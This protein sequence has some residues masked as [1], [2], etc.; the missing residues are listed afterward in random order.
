MIY[1]PLGGGSSAITINTSVITGGTQG[2]VLFIGA[3]GVLQQDNANFFWDDTNNRLGIGTAAPTHLLEVKG[4][5]TTAFKVW[6]GTSGAAFSVNTTGTRVGIGVAS[7]GGALDVGGDRII[8]FV[9]GSGNI[10][11]VSTLSNGTGTMI[12][13]TNNG[14]FGGDVAGGRLNVLGQANSAL[15]PFAVQQGSGTA[16]TKLASFRD[17]SGTETLG[18]TAAGG[19]TVN[20]AAGGNYRFILDHTVVPGG[21]NGDGV[22]L[23]FSAENASGVT[24]DIAY[25]DAIYDTISANDVSMRISTRNSGTPTERIRIDPSGNVGIGTATPDRKIHS[26]V[27]DAGTTTVLYPAR[28]T[29]IS[30]GTPAAGIGTGLEFETQTAAGNNEVGSTIESVTT[31]VTAASEDFDLVFKNMA[32]GAAAAEVAR[33]TSIGDFK[34]VGKTT[35]YNN[36]TTEGYGVPAIYKSDRSTGQTSA[37]TL[38]A[39]T[40][41]GADGSFLVSANVLV[42]TSSAENFTV[43]CTYTDEGNTSRT[44][45]LNFQTIAGVLGTAV[46]FANG[47]VPYEG[48]PVHIRAKASTTITI[49]ST[50]TFTGAT[51]NIE[52]MISQIA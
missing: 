17:Q 15:I 35:L 13:T 37:K 21:A 49:A 46:N 16:T 22:G 2:S 1:N 36:I 27:G 44:L 3:A 24:E 20:T 4:S 29:R 33:I 38:A 42:T 31:D 45:T 48:L 7:P 8:A 11:N 10:N 43:T 25:I 52:E 30:S 26:E 14:R 12:F 6:N 18:I 5:T 34:L 9:G 39:Y 50:G 19:F 40:V 28:L 51:Y 47:A 32:A 41:G 23:T